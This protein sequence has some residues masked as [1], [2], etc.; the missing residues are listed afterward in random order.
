LGASNKKIEMAKRKGGRSV[1]AS[2][3]KVAIQVK[4][5][6]LTSVSSG[7][8]ADLRTRGEGTKGGAVQ[9]KRGNLTDQIANAA[10]QS[11]QAFVE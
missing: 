11:T 6:P 5:S 8:G 9:V 4:S 7:R 3:G 2:K 1:V 10:T